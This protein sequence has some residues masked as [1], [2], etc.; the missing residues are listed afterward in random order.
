[1]A[2]AMFRKRVGSDRTDDRKVS[3]SW[4]TRSWS[5]SLM[6]LNNM[7]ENCSIVSVG[8]VRLFYDASNRVLHVCMLPF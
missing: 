1:M 3:Q 4:T 7:V 8:Y 5:T 6:E 2:L